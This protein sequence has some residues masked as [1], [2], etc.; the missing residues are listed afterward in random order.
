MHWIAI[1]A[2]VVAVLAALGV[3]LTLL[4]VRERKAR[5]RFRILGEVAAVSDAGGSLSDT[6]AAICDILVPE[7]ADFCMIDVITEGSVQRAAV[8]V[9]PGAPPNVEHGLAERRPSV[10]QRMVSG[11]G[12]DSLKPRTFERMTDADLRQL[13]HDP[14]DLAL[15]RS[16][17]IRSAITVAL[18]ERRR[19]TGALTV[20]V[21]WSGRRYR[22][23]DV[24]FARLLSGWIALALDN[25]G[26]FADLERA[27]R[28]RSEIAETLQRGLLP[29]PLPYIPGWSVAAMYRPA[30]A[31]N[32][33]GGDFYDAFRLPGGWMLVIGDVTGRGAGAATVTALARH[34]L[35]TAAALTGDAI[36]TLE[37]L[38][39]AMLSRGEGALCSLVALTI[40]DDPTAAV[41]LAVAGHPPPLVVDGEEVTEAA[42]A[43][44]VLGAFAHAEWALERIDLDPGHQLV[45][46]TDGLI[47][48]RGV[49]A[50]FGEERLRDEVVSGATH[51]ALLVQRLEGSL[52]DFAVEAL[53]D[54][55]TILG[56]ARRPE[57]PPASGPTA[58]ERGIALVERLYDAFNRRDADDFGA[59]CDEQIEF[60]PPVNADPTGGGFPYIGPEGLREYL[61]DAGGVWEELLIHPGEVEM[62][63]DRL[64]VGGRVHARSHDLGIRDMPLAWIWEVRDGRLVRGEVFSDPQRAAASFA[65]LP[66]G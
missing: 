5:R 17:G 8:R 63:G 66:T 47:E 62:R 48:A 18:N 56:I 11:D 65:A 54:D 30:G 29:A 19:V 25:S 15:L 46:V 41:R 43:D 3:Q 42:G 34:T 13:A 64:L 36:M 27:E 9:A 35:R 24:R 16:A 1:F 26:L 45:I 6:F 53:E 40:S 39:R 38:N 23:E 21:A 37:T 61:A 12:A 32:E 22:R 28:A 10:P 60:F 14:A 51:P 20:G 2:V 59:V 31:E 52:Q 57:E 50:R 49:E 55:V 33:V 58:D 7:L 4:L 44:P